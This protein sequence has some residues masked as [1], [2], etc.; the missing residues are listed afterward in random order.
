MTAGDRYLSLVTTP[1]GGRVA[2]ALGLPRPVELR[3]YVP[4]EPALPGPALV[5]GLGA[6]PL[7]DVPGRGAAGARRRRR[8]R[9]G[10][11]RRARPGRDRRRRHRRRGRRRPGGGARA[12][13]P[14]GAPAGPLLP[15]GRGLARLAGRGRPRH[16][17]HPPGAR[18]AVAVPGQGAAGRRHRQPARPQPDPCHRPDRRC[19]RVVPA[20]AALAAPLRFLASARSAFV[21]GQVV[22]VRPHRS[23][24]A[25]PDTWGEP[26]SAPTDGS[27][28]TD[29]GARPLQGRTA[30]VTG[31]ARGI[32]AAIAATLARDGA[33]V[34]C[35]D[36]PAAGQALAG[37]RQP[38]RGYRAAARPGRRRRPAAAGRAR[39]RALRRR[40]RRRA[41]RRNHP[42]PAARQR[43]PRPAWAA[44]LAVNLQAPLRLTRA[45]LDARG[46]GCALGARVVVMSSTSGSPATGARRT[47]RRARPVWSGMVHALAPVLAERDGTVERR[48]ARV[49]RD[50]HDGADAARHPRGR[51]AG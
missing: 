5:A 4:G 6:G 35:L 42:G 37:R 8:G 30:V 20:V 33:R 50:G 1:A 48:R 21:S 40:R 18:G 41:Q 38:C 36:V 29:A 43:R 23:V 12:A 17:R 11:R 45:L 19:R 3:R 22:R 39:R 34:V 15:R 49:H 24:G 7:V 51:A 9:H 47:T 25:S 31:A 27:A 10:G 14:R 13:R 2:Q 28:D 32:G 44:V 16:R 26:D 46:T